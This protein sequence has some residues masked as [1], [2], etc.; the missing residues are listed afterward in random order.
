MAVLGFASSA[1]TADFFAIGLRSGFDAVAS[2]LAFGAGA[3]TGL[4]PLFGLSS[5]SCT[6]NEGFLNRIEI[7][8]CL[9]KSS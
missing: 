7:G 4:R 3:A 1:D 2:A 9:K 8:E 6:V 5:F